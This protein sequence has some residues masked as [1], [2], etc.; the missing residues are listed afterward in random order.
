MDVGAFAALGGVRALSMDGGTIWA[1]GPAGGVVYT[2][3]TGPSRFLGV[4]NDIPG[5][6]FDVALGREHAW[7][8]TRDGVVRLRRLRDGSV[9]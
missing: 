8:A 5:E 9:R 7:I 1:A 3:A 2:R 6:A 4:P